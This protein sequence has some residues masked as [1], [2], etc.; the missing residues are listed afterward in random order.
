MAQ[1]IITNRLASFVLLVRLCSGHHFDSFTDV[2]STHT[3]TAVCDFTSSSESCPTSFSACDP[4][5]PFHASK[6][7]ICGSCTKPLCL[8]TPDGG[9]CP[10]SNS[11]CTQDQKKT[12]SQCGECNQYSCCGVYYHSRTAKWK[13]RCRDTQNGQESTV[14]KT[15]LL[16]HNSLCRQL[17]ILEQVGYS[18][19]MPRL[20]NGVLDW[21]E[22][23][24][25]GL[26]CSSRQ[27]DDLGDRTYEPFSPT[28]V[29]PSLM[30][31]DMSCAANCQKPKCTDFWVPYGASTTP[32]VQNRKGEILDKFECPADRVSFT[33]SFTDSR[34]WA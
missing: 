18:C 16:G 30:Y 15:K 2:N 11:A 4:D 25:D 14:S 33:H 3:Q 17:T 34:V 19:Q 20:T 22:A 12:C 10:N 1:H 6:C 27:A 24:P 13:S 28:A 8:R 23:A 32:Q 5:I 7:S 31:Q 26:M 9:I 21:S 29:N